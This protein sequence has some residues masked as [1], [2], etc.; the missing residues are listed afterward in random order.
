MERAHL[1]DLEL[2]YDVVG[3]GDPLLL[4]HGGYIA[5]FF[6]QPA[7]L[8]I[9]SR[10]RVISYHRRGYE[11]SSRSKAPTTIGQQAA[12]ARAL[13]RHLGIS[14]AH[15]AGHSF[16]GAIGLQLALDAPD[17][18]GS[19]ALL[20]P[21]LV[22]ATPSG[23][24]FVE[25]FAAIRSMYD[26][27]D[28]AGATDTF[29]TAALGPEYRQLL[30]KMLPGAFE[31]AVAHSE[32]AI[33]TEQGA[34]QEWSFTAE[35]AARIQQPVLSVLGME[36]IPICGEIHSLVKQWMPHAEELVV[37]DANHALPYM[38]PRAVAAGLAQFLDRHP[39]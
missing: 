23:P 31:Q 35:D 33:G 6:P 10:Y 19:L 27:G 16:G 15:L 9:A 39:L 14:R 36:S 38:N 3:A 25:A 26:S 4:I 22:S 1:D 29:L 20:E 28:R 8:D 5:T 24:M 37:P 17:L 13:L 11:G 21:A 2:E 30:E 7:E 32:T 12:D 18:V 34:L